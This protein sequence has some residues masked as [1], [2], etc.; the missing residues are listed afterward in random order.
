MDASTIFNKSESSIKLMK[1]SKGY[2]WEIKIYGDNL[3]DVRAKIIEQDK[4]L[5]A[6][7]SSE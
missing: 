5:R 3:D 1:M 2:N 4:K 6:D 7:F